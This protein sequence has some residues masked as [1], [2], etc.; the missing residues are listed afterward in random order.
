MQGYYRFPTVFNDQ[1]VF[2][3]ED[4]L[5]SITKNDLK[6]FALTE[7]ARPIRHFCDSKR[8]IDFLKLNDNKQKFVIV[9]HF[10][11]FLEKTFRDDIENKAELLNF[12]SFYALYSI[13]KLI[14]HNIKFSLKNLS[15]NNKKI[16]LKKFNTIFFPH[17]GI[18]YGDMYKKD[19]FCSKESNSNFYPSN[20]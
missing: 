18:Y 3:S 19:Q 1:I 10:P 9:G 13:L 15:I 20:I 6:A 11:N 2:V 14:Y 8:F 4:D 16:N 17:R 12:Y 5:W 7:M